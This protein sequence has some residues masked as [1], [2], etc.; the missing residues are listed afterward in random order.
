M[1]LDKTAHFLAG[2]AIASTVALYSGDAVL[3]FCA[4]LAAGMAKEVYDLAGFGT[5]DAADLL[6]TVAGAAVVLPLAL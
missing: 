2:S 6:A 5:P 3:G 1:T 4:G